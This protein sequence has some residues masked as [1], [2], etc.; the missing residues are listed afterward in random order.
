MT[1]ACVNQ[2]SSV[3]PCLCET[4]LHT[5]TNLTRDGDEHRHGWKRYERT[6]FCI[7]REPDEGSHG[8]TKARRVL[9][10][11]DLNEAQNTA[12]IHDQGVRQ[13]N[14]LCASVPL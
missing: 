8:G 3:P 1:N 9:I 12:P 5:A 7:H 2:I 6:T 14:F 11:V 10:S 4:S 13:S